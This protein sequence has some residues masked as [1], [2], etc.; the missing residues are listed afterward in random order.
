[1][2]TSTKTIPTLLL[3]SL[4]AFAL[5]GCQPKNSDATVSGLRCEYRANPEGIGAAKPRLSWKEVSN[6]KNQ[7]QTAYQIE[8][9]NSRGEVVWDS[10]R[11][12][13][14]QSQG[15]VYAGR[16]LKAVEGYT[17]KVR[18]WDAHGGVT[19]WSDPATFSTAI[20][21]W[22]AKWIGSDVPQAP[23]PFTTAG[24]EWVATK[25][26]KLGV[27]N[28]SK[29]IDIPAEQKLASA[30]LVLF[31][32]N[33]CTATVN[34]QPAGE[35]VRW[36]KTTA[37]DVTKLFQPGT[38][39]VSLTVTN[40]DGLFAAV[41]GRVLLKFEAGPDL[42]I[43][44]DPSW[45]DAQS[46]GH[47]QRFNTATTPWNTPPLNDQPRI[48][49]DY[50]RKEFNSPQKEV[51]RATASVVALGTYE[52]RLNGT[53]V[54][55]DVLAPG[56]T[57][58]SKRV[59]SQTYDVTKLI[60]PG[61]NAI[62]AIL[63]DG[64]YAGPLAFTGK[65]NYYGGKPRLKVELT[66]E[67][68]DGTQERVVTDETWKRG[69][70][71]IRSAE[72]LLGSEV[73]A[74]KP[75]TGW[76]Q[77]GFD[78]SNWSA[79]VEGMGPVGTTPLKEPLVVPDVSSPPQI[80]ELLP[81]VKI[82]EPSPGV[83]IFDLGQNMSGWSRLKLK[84]SPGQKLVVRYGEFL[85]PDGSLY[86]AN[87][88][89]ATSTDHFTLAGTGEE[90]LEP[91]STFHG[92]RYVE[93]RGLTEKPE[94][95]MVTGVVVHTPMERTGSFECS[96][97]IL[98]QLYH[99]II[100]GQKSNYID[101]PTDCPQR[102]ERAG[103]TGDAE[104]FIPTATYNF[105][106]NPFFTKWLTTLCED[107]QHADGAIADVAPDVL[108]S[109]GA[110]A[111]ADS[112][113]IIPYQIWL[114]YDD[115][116][117]IRDHY[118]A[119]ER[120]M[121][122]LASKTKNSAR[123]FKGDNFGDWLN[124]G[125]GATPEVMDTAYYAY[126]AQLMAEMAHAIGNTQAEAKYSKLHDE[127]KKTFAGF[128]DPDGT[129]RGCSQTGYVLAFTMG[130]VPD[131]LKEKA[132]AKFADEIARFNDHL[133]TGFIGTPRLLQALHIAGRDDLAYRLLQ[134]ETYPSWLFPIKMGATTM[135]ERWD[136]WTPEKGFQT[137]DM[138]SFNHYA[139]G[140]VGEYLYGMIG[141]IQAET[142]G[143]KKIRIAPVMGNGIAWANVSYDSIYGKI[144]SNWKLDQGKLSMTVVIP[145]NTTATIRIPTSSPDQVQE[146]GTPV[147]KVQGIKLLQ[148]PKSES[149]ALFLEVGSG[150]YQFTAPYT[151]PSST[152]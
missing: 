75:I 3:S 147:A 46:L 111:W 101:V 107:S 132:A 62:A 53:R 67:Y 104:F 64:W 138:N 21:D 79:V 74:S 124:K 52:L 87:L 17:W 135:W 38:N 121:D 18:I 119:M 24:L 78:A 73:D 93:V 20:A 134:Q 69:E 12:K 1:M 113:I 27:L 13:S 123:K 126:D 90:T 89:S 49:V 71:P 117:V 42:D 97:P 151:L 114:S 23:N 63:A 91:F 28:L 122:W 16:P 8:V 59:T 15:I 108:G 142:P 88:R 14:D 148:A 149:G 80:Q 54:G 116:S 95:S 118:P 44:V 6:G 48:P 82:T 100:W 150:S 9:S 128:F 105:N 120:F 127:I 143:F 144:T 72:L 77:P 131:D 4:L 141:G 60:H 31:P 41:I 45:G 65:R 139:F 19:A 40:S 106:V 103:W 152:H 50:L 140:S 99:N 110:T 83:A 137:V 29:Q 34:G 10:G 39:S 30:T 66:I 61:T 81:T 130:L 146:S 136:G 112:A 96:S 7:N 145:P 58:F 129:L 94:P 102:D 51:H 56:W 36:D 25:G 35:A 55:E 86:T 98:N 92:F 85:N 57:D 37:L 133:A 84:G 22:H 33:F 2:M 70:G 109:G 68:T 32:D 26:K 11:V 47:N 125:G 76:D 43:P 115:T 5:F